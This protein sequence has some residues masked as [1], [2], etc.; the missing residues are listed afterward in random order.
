M[1]KTLT[2]DKIR[3]D[4][5][6]KFGEDELAE[7]FLNKRMQY[8]KRYYDGQRVLEKDNPDIL[9]EIDEDERL[10]MGELVLEGV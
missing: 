1:N 10:E 5:L 4:I 9:K 3:I 2:I 6:S 7:L 8:I